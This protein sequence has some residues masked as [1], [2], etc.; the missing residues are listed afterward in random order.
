MVEFVRR[1]R[2]ALSRD[3]REELRSYL[4]EV[5]PL[6]DMADHELETWRRAGWPDASRLS[7]ESDPTGEHAAVYV[8]R[9]SQPAT[10]FVQHPPVAAARRYHQFYSLCLENRAAAASSLKEAADTARGHERQ[11]KLTVA[12]RRLRESQLEL[13][14]ALKALHGLQTLIADS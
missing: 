4:R 5:G 12:N 13:A 8:W 10:K 9:V 11:V 7:L 1:R 3:D 14:K 2:R 6:V